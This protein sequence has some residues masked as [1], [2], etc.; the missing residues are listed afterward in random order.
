M[1]LNQLTDAQLVDQINVLGEEILASDSD[2]C[3]FDTICMAY[4][5]V[6]E[7][8]EARGLWA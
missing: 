4:D 7:E 3:G 8:L 1:T 2:E 6:Q 5:A